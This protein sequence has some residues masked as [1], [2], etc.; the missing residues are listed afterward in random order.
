MKVPVGF[1]AWIYANLARITL[2]YI[3]STP[4]LISHFHIEYATNY[5]GS[6]N[7]SK[8]ILGFKY[9]SSLNPKEKC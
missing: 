9:N 6:C 5:F 3:W 2:I 7:L 8:Q 1:E 4:I